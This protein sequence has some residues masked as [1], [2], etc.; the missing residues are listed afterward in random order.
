MI[1]LFESVKNKFM[2]RS[3]KPKNIALLVDGPNVL[4]REFGN[5]D[6]EKVKKELSKYGQAKVLQVFL[7]Q[8]ASN[9]LIEAVSNQGFEVIVMPCDV[10][11]GMAVAATELFFNPHIDMIALMTRDSHFQSVVTR[12]KMHGKGTIVLGM[13]PSFSVALKN[14]A[15]IVIMLNDE[16][17]R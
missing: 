7:D 8:Y 5:I 11:V 1:F 9:K 13:E 3:A 15:D 6:L 14:S 12:A 17:A 4:R 16:Q 10:D 2:K